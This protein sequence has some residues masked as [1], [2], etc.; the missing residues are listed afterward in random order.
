MIQ[1][2]SG[3]ING[4]LIACARYRIYDERVNAL[5]KNK[6]QGRGGVTH[7]LFIINLPHYVSGSSFVGFQGDPW[8]SAHIDDPR[9]SHGDTIEPVHAMSAKISELFIG[10]YINDIQSL[11]STT[12]E[13]VQLQNESNSDN[14]SDEIETE[15][16]P[17]RPSQDLYREDELGKDSDSEVLFVRHETEGNENEPEIPHGHSPDAIQGSQELYMSSEFNGQDSSQLDPL[18][19]NKQDFVEQHDDE[20]PTA[21]PA[22]EEML[23][24]DIEDIDTE[25]VSVSSPQE[26]RVLQNIDT[27]F[28]AS[29]ENLAHAVSGLIEDNDPSTNIIHPV[30]RDVYPAVHDANEGEQAQDNLSKSQYMLEQVCAEHPIGIHYGNHQIPQFQKAQ[31]R[32]LYNCIQAAASKVEDL[33]KD[34]STQRVTRLTKLIQRLPDRLGKKHYMSLDSA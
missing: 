33:T 19:H 24:V 4:D 32:R 20:N 2:D 18:A 13:Q 34:R 30:A 3:H 6:L 1:C 26:R 31:C 27:T 9:P 11:L 29:Q 10:G 5:E 15:D 8:I 14:S 17:M 7:V 22:S 28:V 12:C 21:K 16:S 25:L 23:V